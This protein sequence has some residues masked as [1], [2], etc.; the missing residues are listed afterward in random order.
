M[1]VDR[2]IAAGVL[3]P[4]CVLSD[5]FGQPRSGRIGGRLRPPFLFGVDSLSVLTATLRLRPLGRGAPF[6]LPVL[7]IVSDAG[8]F[9]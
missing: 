6:P 1:R 4:L 8:L 2:L 7:H 3:V 9:S 5:A